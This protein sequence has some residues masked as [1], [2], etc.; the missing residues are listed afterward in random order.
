MVLVFVVVLAVLFKGGF[1]PDMQAFVIGAIVG[2]GLTAVLSFYFGS[3]RNSAA[4]DAMI[5]Q[6]ANK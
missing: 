1:S 5:S 6:L 3:S 2:G 4:K